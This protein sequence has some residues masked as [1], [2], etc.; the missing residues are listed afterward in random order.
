M[1]CFK[2]CKTQDSQAD[3]NDYKLKCKALEDRVKQLEDQI[4]N[5]QH[6]STEQ[7]FVFDFSAVNAFSVERHWKDYRPC[8]IVGY[9]VNEPCVD[10][11]KVVHNKEVV[12]EWYLY[13]SNEQHAKIVE[14]FRASLKGK[15]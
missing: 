14:Q 13:C 4:L 5:I 8:T 15:K 1:F 10:S 2:Q 11:D 9:T 7:D 12:R 6:E 3:V